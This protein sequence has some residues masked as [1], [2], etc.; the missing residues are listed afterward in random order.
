LILKFPRLFELSAD[1]ECS[2]EEMRRIL[3]AVE[4]RERVW[5][6]RL[7]AWE[8]ES[9]RECL[10]LRHNIVLQD[11]VEDTWRWLLDPIHVNLVRG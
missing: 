4:G 5:R 11:N 3:R 1:K 8:E 6:R 7:L 10:M 9:V 2:M